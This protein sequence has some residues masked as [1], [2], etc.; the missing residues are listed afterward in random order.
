MA[1]A[2]ADAVILDPPLERIRSQQPRRAVLL[3]PG[4]P[5]TVGEF[6]DSSASITRTDGAR[7]C[8]NQATGKVEPIVTRRF[9]IASHLGQSALLA[10]A[11]ACAWSAR[12]G[13]RRR[14]EAFV[15]T[16]DNRRPCITTQQASRNS[17]QQSARRPLRHLS[18]PNFTNRPIARRTAHDLPH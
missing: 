8:G 14:G 16:A 2:K 3:Q 10:A 4:Q 1:R 11:M 13:S 7:H 17:R 6:A 9:L 15:A 5:K 12:T 18:R